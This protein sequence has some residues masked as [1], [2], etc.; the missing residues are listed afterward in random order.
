MLSDSDI[1]KDY[2]GY[3]TKYTFGINHIILIDKRWWMRDKVLDF[4]Y[5]HKGNGRVGESEE[6]HAVL[7]RVDEYFGGVL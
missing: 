3:Y 1:L 6:Y 4:P 2:K 7:E 5:K